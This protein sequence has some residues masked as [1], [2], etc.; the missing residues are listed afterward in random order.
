MSPVVCELDGKLDLVASRRPQ[1]A[2]E[3]SQ[4]L[5]LLIR[6]SQRFNDPALA[7]PSA[8]MTRWRVGTLPSPAAL[9]HAPDVPG[10]QTTA[11]SA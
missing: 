1:L 3:G 4:V 10:L 9:S 5:G 11:A 2:A 8:A 7:Q 6:R